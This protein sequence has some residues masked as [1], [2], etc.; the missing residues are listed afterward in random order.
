MAK[1]LFLCF[2]LSPC[3]WA[4]MVVVINV[5]SPISQLSRQEVADIFLGRTP[6]LPNME[7]VIPIE[8][9]EN[10]DAYRDF[11]ANVTRKNLTQLNAYWAR[12]VFAGRASPPQE[13]N[14]LQ[15]R[16]LIESN[17]SYIAYVD[18]TLLSNKMKVVFEY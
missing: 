2:F 4:E 15:A 18:R 3:C 13:M 8:S 11:H 7:R 16:K 12:M 6:F 1:W 5:D 10:S 14:G 17:R 9:L